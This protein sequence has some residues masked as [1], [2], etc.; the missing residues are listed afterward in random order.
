M[1]LRFLMKFEIYMK[2]FCAIWYNIIMFL[3][4]WNTNYENGKNEKPFRVWKTLSNS[5][6]P[7]NE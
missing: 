7:F 1:Y 4:K 2:C 5:N 3:Q 6:F